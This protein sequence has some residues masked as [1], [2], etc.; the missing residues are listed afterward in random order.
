MQS[1]HV[2]PIQTHT[3]KQ[4]HIHNMCN[5]LILLITNANNICNCCF[6]VH[7]DDFHYFEIF[8]IQIFFCSENFNCNFTETVIS[9]PTTAW[10]VLPDYD[11]LLV[12]MMDSLKIARLFNFHTISDYFFFATLKPCCHEYWQRHTNRMAFARI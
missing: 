10:F 8:S 5:H 3:N 2:R 12:Y 1:N 7:F 4:T 6:S 11:D 9:P